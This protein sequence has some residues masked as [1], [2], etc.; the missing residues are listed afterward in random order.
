MRRRFNRCPTR[1]ARSGGFV[2]D[3][4]GV[5]RVVAA[6]TP[7][8]VYP[9]VIDEA[10][11]RLF[12]YREAYK[13]R[14]RGAS[15]LSDGNAPSITGAM[16]RSGAGRIA[17]DISAHR[18]SKVA[19]KIGA[20]IYRSREWQG[21]R[22]ACKAA[23]GG[24][25]ADCGGFGFECPPRR[26]ALPGRSADSHPGRRRVAVPVVSFSTTPIAAAHRVGRTTLSLAR[27]WNGFPSCF[28]FGVGVVTITALMGR[29][30]RPPAG[31]PQHF[32]PFA[33]AGLALTGIG[34][35]L[36]RFSDGESESQTALVSC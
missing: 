25:C 26:A 3:L 36:S 5:Y 32:E 28:R 16:M 4:G 18:G 34:V 29:P 35:R 2:W 12:A 20:A 21:L 15:E 24:L 27:R 19:G 8:L 1:R 33:R 11:A 10:V 6:V 30:R 22:A 13:P 31:F 17:Q 9:T 7:S 14:A 23:A